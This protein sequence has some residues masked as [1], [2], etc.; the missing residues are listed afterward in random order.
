MNEIAKFLRDGLQ[1]YQLEFYLRRRQ[2]A[3]AC[4]NKA[5][6]TACKSAGALH[7]CLMRPGAGFRHGGRYS[8]SAFLRETAHYFLAINAHL[9]GIQQGIAD[10]YRTVIDMPFSSFTPAGKDDVMK[11]S[12][13]WAILM[14][15]MLVATH[16]QTRSESESV[17]EVLLGACVESDRFLRH[18]DYF[19]EA[20]SMRFSR[21][22]RPG[23]AGRRKVRNLPTRSQGDTRTE[24]PCLPSSA[25]T[26]QDL[27]DL[28][29]HL[30]Q[31]ARELFSW[32]ARMYGLWY[33]AP[34]SMTRIMQP[35]WQDTRS[36]RGQ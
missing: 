4:R 2:A 6:P 26:I 30:A 36:L 29:R 9:M 23:V 31:H 24:L 22:W 20:H 35:G 19:Q 10:L 1:D 17:A 25:G 8:L 14:D 16:L 18:V 13:E 5:S 12:Q 7:P 28:Y 32:S 21:F 3:A 34:S 11:L 33:E 15:R 27:I